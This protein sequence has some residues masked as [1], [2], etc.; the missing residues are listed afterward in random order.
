MYKEEMEG[1]EPFHRP[2]NLVKITVFKSL[3]L[4]SI[5]PRHLTPILPFSSPHNLSLSSSVLSPSPTAL[6]H[7]VILNS[8]APLIIQFGYN[9]QRRL[10][11]ILRSGVFLMG[12]YR[13]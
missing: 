3:I 5:L 13:S 7:V 10:P 8:F 2:R 9:T 6:L 11:F 12:W 4:P 1:L